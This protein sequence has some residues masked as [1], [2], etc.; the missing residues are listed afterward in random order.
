MIRRR[1]NVTVRE[2]TTKRS[3]CLIYT[4]ANYT[5]YLRWL[6]EHSEHEKTD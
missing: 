3:T 1:N 4:F 5:A 6:K 2:K